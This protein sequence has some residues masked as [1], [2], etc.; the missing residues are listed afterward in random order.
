VPPRLATFADEV[1][2]FHELLAALHTDLADESLIAL[3]SDEQLLQGP[4]AD[5]MTHAGQLALLRRLAGSPVPSEDFIE[6]TIDTSNVSE[7]QPPPAA[8]DDWWR[9]DE[10]P[11]PPG[12]GAQRRMTGT[13]RIQ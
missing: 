7:Q 3:I 12:A 2:R 10:P 1:T 13:N 4:L 6:A 11:P 9:A 5:A 8:P